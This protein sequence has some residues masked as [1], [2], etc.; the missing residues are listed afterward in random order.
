M[1]T[2]FEIPL[3]P[4]WNP[5][6]NP[7]IL[8]NP[9]PIQAF[10]KVLNS[11]VTSN[12]SYDPVKSKI[13]I[14]QKI[15]WVLDEI[16]DFS[17]SLDQNYVTLELIILEN[18]LSEARIYKIYLI[19][20]F[21]FFKNCGHKY[22]EMAKSEAKNGHNSILMKL[23]SQLWIGRNTKTCQ[24]NICGWWC[25]K[26]TMPRKWKLLCY[27]TQKLHLLTLVRMVNMSPY[28]LNLSNL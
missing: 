11:S 26:G 15:K 2:I 6:E 25:Q 21:H 27:Y 13:F 24:K 16:L 22:P 10:S 4:N 20:F 3:D 5:K 19:A 18:P 8:K 9:C 23:I 17:L 28:E 14:W 7:I 12:W 1:S